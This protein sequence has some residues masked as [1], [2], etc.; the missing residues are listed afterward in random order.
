ML[1]YGHVLKPR[2]LA[3]VRGAGTD[4]DGLYYIKSVTH[5]IQRGQYTQSFS[6]ARGGLK[7]TISKVAS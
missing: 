1:R 6:L 7:S 5:N 4:F 3:A 2:K